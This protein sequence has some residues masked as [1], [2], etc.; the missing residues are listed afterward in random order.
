MRRKRTDDY[1]WDYMAALLPIR[2]LGGDK[3]P[4]A[5]ETRPSILIAYA[6]EAERK[7]FLEALLNLKWLPARVRRAVTTEL[8][9]SLQQEK[10]GI[11]RAVTI[12][13]RQMIKD[14]EARM[15]ANGERP[16]RGDVHTAAVA[17]VAAGQG[18]DAETLQKRLYRLDHPDRRSRGRS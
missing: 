18:M 8:G 3:T 4:V 9:C 5:V 17:E 7:L 14:V 6:D 13:L 16:A 2:I 12:T 1:G 10:A 15:R 11:E